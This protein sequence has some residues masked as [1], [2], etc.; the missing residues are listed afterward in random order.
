MV[1]SQRSKREEKKAVVLI[2]FFQLHQKELI[3]LKIE[4]APLMCIKPLLFD[5]IQSVND[6]LIAT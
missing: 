5:S 4:G 3:Y 2:T 6:D 1:L